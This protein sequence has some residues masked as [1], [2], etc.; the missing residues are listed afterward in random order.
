MKATRHNFKLNGLYNKA[1]ARF[2]P[3]F[4]FTPKTLRSG[5]AVLCWGKAALETWR[6]LGAPEDRPALVVFPREQAPP[7]VKALAHVL[8]PGEHPFP[9]EGSFRAGERMIGFFERLREERVRRL[10]VFLSGGASS[11]AWVLPAGLGRREL[12]IALEG[13][14]ASGRTI[15]D[16]NEER[17]GLCAL[18]AGEAA[19]ILRT[20][21]PGI[22]I[23][24]QVISDVYP[25]GLE[26]V[27]SGPFFAREHLGRKLHHA[28]VAD[29][30]MLGEAIAAGARR[31]GMRVLARHWGRTWSA[32]EWAARARR[33]IG[34][35][36]GASP[37]L[38]VATGEP[39][40]TI[41]RARIPAAA[42]P[43]SGGRLSHLALC[44]ARELAPLSKTREIELL[45][46]ATD[47]KDGNS[48]SSGSWMDG[49]AMGSLGAGE[50]RRALTGFRSA[51]LL[52]EAGVLIPEAPSVTNLQDVVMIRA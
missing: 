2:E 10:R 40:V 35:S 34:R 39:S 6:A 42:R 16:I 43:G 23:D 48:G 4:L 36:R 9:G 33:E 17:G 20:L 21:C 15:R 44:L 52:R 11:L 30:A 18:K 14:L 38:W 19:R 31:E 28:C 45:C 22:E 32:E 47:G 46:R 12:R 51:G 49:P 27:G 24:V 25:F 8:A 7:G 5:D 50:I 26:T 37:V 13:A 41:P 29:S 1:L 3:R